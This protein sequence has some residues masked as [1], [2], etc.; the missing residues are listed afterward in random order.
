MEFSQRKRKERFGM[1]K[2][3]IYLIKPSRSNLKV[4]PVKI[5]ARIY[6]ISPYKVIHA[7][8]QDLRPEEPRGD[9]AGRRRG[10]QLEKVS[11]KIRS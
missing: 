4:P 1:F 9:P 3:V 7:A 2:T 11:S 5:T 8:Q 10:E 6:S